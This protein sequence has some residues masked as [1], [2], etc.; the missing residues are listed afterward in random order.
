MEGTPYD[1]ET[2]QREIEHLSSSPSSVN[3]TTPSGNILQCSIPPT[4]YPP[5]EDT[6]LLARIVHNLEA[7]SSQHVL[8][9]GSGSGVISVY[10]AQEGHSVWSC[11]INPYAVAATKK[12][13]QDHDVSITVREGGPGPS[14]EITDLQWSGGNNFDCILWNLPYLPSM[15][16][17]QRLGP[18]EEASFLSEG[19]FSLYEHML[20]KINATDILSDHG[21]AYFV[22]SSNFEF[23][24]CI[25]RAWH[26]GLCAKL[27]DQMEL[28]D[29]TIAVVMVWK[30]FNRS[31][32]ILHFDEV[33]STN[34]LALEEGTEIGTLYAA[35]RQ[36]QGRGRGSNPWDSTN[37]SI[38][39]SWVIADG[40]HIPA[41]T[42]QLAAG[43]H[44][45]LLLRALNPHATFCMK[46]PN[47]LFVSHDGSTWKKCGGILI[48]STSQGEK[49][50]VVLGVGVNFLSENPDYGHIFSDEMCSPNSNMFHGCIAS[51]FDEND[52]DLFSIDKRIWANIVSELLSSF[53]DIFDVIIDDEHR[54]VVDVSSA[55]A[56]IVSDGTSTQS[57]DDLSDVTIVVRR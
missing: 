54:K 31:S 16:A 15:G 1:F 5:R 23:N 55:G 39:L 14:S 28:G 2:V 30:P 25:Q 6:D 29:E 43:Y 27:V 41:P 45:L 56:L 52:S 48:E 57:Y 4:V 22:V 42:V 17:H 53:D 26:H 18:L 11:D 47:D 8:E 44:L 51:M 46:Y 32:S 12:L 24:S 3:W 21:K 49:H 19:N 10:A 20:K 50:R 40:N 33:T 34:Q 38:A 13:A 7:G 37:Q 9:I 35:R 36:T